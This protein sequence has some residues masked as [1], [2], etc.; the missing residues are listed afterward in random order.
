MG[1]DRPGTRHTGAVYLSLVNQ[2][3]LLLQY[4][5]DMLADLAG[6]H[7]QEHYEAP[8]NTLWEANTVPRAAPWSM[9]AAKSKIPRMPTQNAS[10]VC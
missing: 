1:G 7:P 8:G 3:D 4:C 2:C 9:Q 5:S 10:S 6:V